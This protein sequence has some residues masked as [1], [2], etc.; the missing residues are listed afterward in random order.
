MLRRGSWGQAR[1]GGHLPRIASG[2]TTGERLL[3]RVKEGG[4]LS[5]KVLGCEPADSQ[6][7]KLGIGWDSAHIMDR[8][9]VLGPR[10]QREDVWRMAVSRAGCGL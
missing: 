4:K 3:T 5:A 2:S 8:G 7:W 6:T 10:L 9:K 1:P